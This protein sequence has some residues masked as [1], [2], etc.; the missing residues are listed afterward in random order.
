MILHRLTLTNVGIFHGENHFDLT[1]RVKY[2]RRRPIILFGGKNGAGKTTLLE[3]IRLVLYGPQ[4]LHDRISRQDYLHELGQ[5]IYRNGNSA[6]SPRQAQIALEFEHTHAG[7]SD[8]YRVV[9]RWQ[10]NRVN[11][12]ESLSIQKNGEDLQETNPD[13]WQDFL[14]ELIPPGL[15]QL[16]FFDGEKIQHLAAD[17]GSHSL[18]TAIKSLLGLDVVERLRSDLTILTRRNLH[19]EKDT[20]PLREKLNAT[21]QDIVCIKKQLSEFEAV[22]REQ[23]E[24]IATLSR[25]I[26][27]QEQ[28]LAAEG[29]GYAAKRQLLQ[30]D[31]TRLD[32]EI[33]AT[34]DKL[35][36]LAAGL[37]PFAFAPDLCAQL[38]QQLVAE[39]NSE[40]SRQT[41]EQVITAL[42]RVIAEVAAD[43]FWTDL[44][45]AAATPDFRSLLTSKLTKLTQRI[46]TPVTHGE[47]L[48]PIHHLSEKETSLLLH[49]LDQVATAVPDET[50]TLCH[51]LETL[52][53]SLQRITADLTRAPS[54]DVLKP[55]L[56]ELNSLHHQFAQAQIAH[57]HT[58]E[59]IRAASI[60][61]DNLSRQYDKLNEELFQGKNRSSRLEMARKVDQT[62]QRYLER[63]TANKVRELRETLARCFNSLCRK[64]DLLQRI[65]IDPKTFSILIQN[66][67]GR[68]LHKKQLSSGEKEIFA[69][70]LLWA[71]AQTS[72]RP[73]PMIIDTPLGRLD[74][75]HRR[76][77][78]ENYFPHASH[79]VIVLSTD[80]EIDR[81]LYDALRP[82][83]SHAYHLEYSPLRSAVQTTEGYFWKGQR[84]DDAV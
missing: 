76:N 81:H 22:E 11:V 49:Q 48:Q 61:R 72:G 1:P 74:S 62:L 80:T 58:T 52:N 38:R 68:T 19:G 79:Q 20:E 25:T 46:T 9:R 15:A 55:Y 83:I 14:K 7:V 63:L 31:R 56:E 84:E 44:P 29:G 34:E 71:L 27:D 18:A 41:R 82:H 23:H 59:Q 70:S 69:I 60:E 45:T 35:R 3:A 6:T 4:A 5:R 66:K 51:A 42:Q 39:Q 10:R 12:S 64:G 24:T 75:D 53:Q 65:D 77:L 30:A 17:H 32:Q 43:A 13:Q 33:A 16:F 54:D 78:I 73:L 8:Y 50:R 37:L 47:H 67:D 57:A 26:E 21:E 40:R 2:G 36:E 28:H